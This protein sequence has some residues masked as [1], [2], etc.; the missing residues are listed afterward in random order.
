MTD[1]RMMAGFPII[2][3]TRVITYAESLD[4]LT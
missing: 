2:E 1:V 3:L 4:S